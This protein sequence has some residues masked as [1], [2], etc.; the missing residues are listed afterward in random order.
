TN[1]I[2]IR[3]ADPENKIAQDVY[4]MIES[5]DFRTGQVLIDVLVVE[6]S[7]NDSEQINA[8]WKDLIKNPLKTTNTLVNVG[9]DHGFISSDDPTSL[10]SGFKAFLTSNNKMKLFLNALNQKGKVNVVSSPHI[11]TANHREATFK[12]GEKL[13]IIDSVRPSDGGQITTFRLEDASLELIVTPHINRSG[14]IDMEVHQTINAVLEDTYDPKSGTARLTTREA[15]TNLTVN[16]GETIILGGFIENKKDQ[17][18][19][20]IPLLS[21]IPILGKLFTSVR[22]IN[23][24]TELMV[25]IT[26]KVLITREDA[27]IATKTMVSRSHDKE[28]TMALLELR[29]KV[30]PTLEPKQVIIIDRRSHNWNYGLN[31]SKIEKLVWETPQKIDPT[32][33]DLPLEGSAPFGF[34]MSRR[35]IPAPVRTYLK[36]SQGVIFKKQFEIDN[37]E[38]FQKIGLKIACD[39]AASVYIN[40]ILVDEDPM[41]KMKDGH[42][43]HYWNRERNDI[44]AGLLSKGTNSV[45][46]FLG[47]EKDNVDAYFDMMLIGQIK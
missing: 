36:A 42:D 1:S 22:K 29:K 19:H 27:K 23:T 14:E 37:P 32:V 28:K 39:N 4:D 35:L 8:E 20:R 46:V 34:G 18:E 5:V 30:E 12:I 47:S 11:V 33:L 24:K 44:P 16:D 3:L 21:N 15:K 10:T 38:I 40:G 26:P 6:L 41:M 31:D 13:P 9:I 7:I 2:I 17:V 25:F 45:V 43:F